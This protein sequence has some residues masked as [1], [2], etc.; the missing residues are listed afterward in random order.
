MPICFPISDV[1]LDHLVSEVFIRFILLKVKFYLCISYLMEKY[2]GMFKVSCFY[3]ILPTK[4]RT[5]GVY[6]LK[7][8]LIWWE[9]N[10]NVQK[11]LSV[12]L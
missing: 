4:F 6:Y 8:L 2:Y 7:L 5:I 10:D 1:N 9:P 12:F 3:K 11:Y